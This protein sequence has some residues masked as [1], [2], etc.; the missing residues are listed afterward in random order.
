MSKFFV[1]YD[2]EGNI[3]SI[4]NEKQKEGQFLE[5][6][7]KEVQDFLNGSKPFTQFKIH[8]L[9]TGNKGIKLA[10]DTSS[11]VYTDFCYVQSDVEGDVNVTHNSIDK[12]WEI[13]LNYN[14]SPKK[15]EFFICKNDDINFLIRK[16]LVD[17]KNNVVKF[18]STLEDD[19]D[20]LTV[21]TKKVYSSYGLKH[22]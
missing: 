5:V 7:E 11:L 21:L 20:N 18:E 2:D 15:M 17:Q 6:E 22:V 14:L 8:N 19:I 4:T 13:K 1:Y 3:L 9:T 16:I 10:T 12:C